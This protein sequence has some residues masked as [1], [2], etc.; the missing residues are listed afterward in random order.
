MIYFDAFK[1]DFQSDPFIAISSHIY[2]IIDDPKLQSKY[3]DI[4]KRVA[5]ILMKTTLKIGISA[6]TLG[7]VKGTEFEGIE[8]ILKM[9]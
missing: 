3:L 5:S 4:T 8:M 7:A 9:D 1:N 2:S 6:L